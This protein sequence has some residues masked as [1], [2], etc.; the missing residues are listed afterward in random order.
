MSRPHDLTEPGLKPT[1]IK[2][3]FFNEKEEHCI[4]VSSSLVY[5]RETAAMISVCVY[6]WTCSRV[7]FIHPS[8]RV[9]NPYVLYSSYHG[10]MH[11][12]G[13]RA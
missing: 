1:E 11:G 9:Q 6:M 7:G 10:F 13:R 8:I 5:L 12:L 4:S 2:G 3:S